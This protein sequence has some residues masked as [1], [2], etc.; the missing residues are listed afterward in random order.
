MSADASDAVVLE[1]PAPAQDS[2][3]ASSTTTTTVSTRRAFGVEVIM[4][5]VFMFLFPWDCT[6]VHRVCKAWNKAWTTFNTAL[7][8]ATNGRRGLFPSEFSLIG[9]LRRIEEIMSLYIG[10]ELYDLGAKG[11]RLHCK[12]ES[13][14]L[15]YESATSRVP[16]NLSDQ[17]YAQALSLLGHSLLLVVRQ[18]GVKD[19][20]PAAHDDE[21]GEEEEKVWG[22]V[23]RRFE[24]VAALIM[25]S[26]Q[27]L[28]RYHVKYH[29]K[30]ALSAA[31]QKMLDEGRGRLRQGLPVVVPRLRPRL[32]THDEQ[33]KKLAT[34]NQ[35]MTLTSMLRVLDGVLAAIPLGADLAEPAADIVSAA[36]AAEGEGPHA[37]VTMLAYAQAASLSCE[38]VLVSRVRVAAQLA[39]LRA[40]AD[41]EATGDFSASDNSEAAAGCGVGGGGGGGGKQG[42]AADEE[43]PGVVPEP[44]LEGPARAVPQTAADA[45]AVS[46]EA[47]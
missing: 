37:V 33:V 24:K 22:T 23:T 5:H 21:G 17:L 20:S 13:Y 7:V 6:P 46:D 25:R 42:G 44:D 16:Y 2:P 34:D 15:I 45:G 40:Q 11:P 26:Y 3:A 1:Q 19:N 31:V 12:N 10:L 8:A 9:R 43:M 4:H 14:R 41:A 32:L 35:L 47:R 39:V 38:Q 27:Y 18:A 30:D 29:R 36:L 28:D